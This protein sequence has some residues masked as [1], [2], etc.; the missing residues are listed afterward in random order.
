MGGV[1]GGSTPSRGVTPRL[2]PAMA[3]RLSAGGSRLQSPLR[4]RR[5]TAALEQVHRAG[6]HRSH[7]SAPLVCAGHRTW[8]MSSVQPLGMVGLLLA[9]RTLAHCDLGRLGA[10]LLGA[11]GSC[12]ASFYP[13]CSFHPAY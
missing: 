13:A 12:A 11:D 6:S 10:S 1:P 3:S 2:K 5:W 4:A 9:A 8:G 7:S